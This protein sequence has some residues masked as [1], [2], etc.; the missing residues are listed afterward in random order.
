MATSQSYNYNLTR[1]QILTEALRNIGALPFGQTMSAAQKDDANRSLNMMAKSWVNEGIGLWL[2]QETVIY[3]QND[4]IQYSLGPNGDHF[5]AASDAVKTELSAAAASGA[6]SFSVDSITGISVGDNIGIELDSGAIQWT[7]VNTIVGTTITPTTVLSG[8]AAE[9]NHVYVYTGA[10]TALAVAAVA[11]NTS[12]TV[13]SFDYIYEDDEIGV[14]LDAGT[15][16]WTTVSATPTTT[17]VGLDAAITGNAAI[18]NAVYIGG[19]KLGRPLDFL[20]ARRVAPDGLEV[21]LRIISRDEYM[22]LSEKTVESIPNCIYY[23]R[24]RGHGILNVWPEPSDT[25]YYIKAT[26]KREVQDLDSGTED[27]D[28]P[29]EFFEAF[30]LNLALRLA[31]KYGAI[32]HQELKYQAEL[33]KFHAF[34]FDRESTSIYVKPSFRRR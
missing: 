22:A 12:V 29:P 26:V 32:V 4:T 20:E 21:P 33:S 11:T 3:L 24:Q 28:F 8:A 14:L 16:D 9:D 17:T 2:N 13:D 15:I 19:P 10:T 23:D 34:G 18:D 25:Q 7:M 1:D 6:A 30:A 27:C 31:P 5:A